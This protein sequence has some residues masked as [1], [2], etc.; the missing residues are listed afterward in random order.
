MIR[1]NVPCL[2]AEELREIGGVLESGYLTQGKKVTEFE[3]IVKKT[4][5]S[6]H[7]FAM[8]SATTALHLS[9][10]A[11]GIE[12]GD[13]VLVSDFTFPACGNVIVQA[14]AIP[15]CVDVMPD[16][17]AMDPADLERRI[18]ERT[19]AIMVVHPFGLPADMDPVL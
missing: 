12:P 18:T 17:Y 13:E 1:L 2:G 3:G 10:V 4:V 19:R 8:S 15:V 9:L 5:G 16:T 6:R 7:G 14:G 11:L